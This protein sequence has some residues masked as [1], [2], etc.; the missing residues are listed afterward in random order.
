[1][2]T[3]R[4]LALGVLLLAFGAMAWMFVQ[5]IWIPLYRRQETARFVGSQET[6]ALQVDVEREDRQGTRAWSVADQQAIARL[7]AGLQNAEYAPQN[8]PPASDQKYRLRIKRSDSR[9]DEY[10]V[11]LGSEGQMHDRLYVLR[12]SGGTVVYGTAF[13]TPELRSA[14]QQVL[15]PPAPK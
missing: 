4:S 10:E 11:V 15:V 7:K 6:P 8:D 13:N 9:I 12:R 1:M 14:L 3:R 5:V 2:R